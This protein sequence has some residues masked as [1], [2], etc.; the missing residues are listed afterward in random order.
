M[1]IALHG[2]NSGAGLCG[3]SARSPR[4][5]QGSEWVDELLTLFPTLLTGVTYCNRAWILQEFLLCSRRILFGKHQVHFLCNTVRYCE[6]I[7]DARGPGGA[8]N[9]NPKQPDFFC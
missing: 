5:P 8:L 9:T 2:N 7:D 4:A 1:I 3:V 6:S